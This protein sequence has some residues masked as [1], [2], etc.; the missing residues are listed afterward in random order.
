MTTRSAQWLEAA[1][2]EWR[3]LPM[4][5]EWLEFKEAKT[6]FDIEKLGEYFSA[7]SNEARLQ[8]RAEGWLIFG[9]VDRLPRPIVGTQ[10]KSD[11]AT[12]DALK[13]QVADQTSQRLTF[14]EIHELNLPEGRVLMFEI[15]AALPGIPTAWKGHFFGRDGEA[16]VALNPEEYER[17][18]AQPVRQDWS[19]EV[20][21][22]ATLDDLEPE[23]VAFARAQ[24]LKKNP[25]HGEE[26]VEWTIATF[27]NKAKICVS[28]RVTRA[29]L[30]LLGKPEAA[31]HLSPAVAEMSWRLNDARGEMRDYE[32]FGP[33]F[34]FAGDAV[35][36]KIRNLK[37]RHMP[38]GSLF[39]EEVTQ[40]DERVLREAL[41]NCIAHQDYGA[42]ARVTIV[43][44]DDELVLTN[45]GTFIPRTV[46]HVIESDQPPDVYR[47][48]FLAHAMVNLNMIDTM[49]SGIRRM[50]NVQRARSF[51]LP[52]YDLA[53]ADKVV[54]RISG[55]ILDVNY[56]KLLLANTDLGLADVIALDKVQKK[57]KLDDAAF[58]RLRRAGLIAGRRPNVFVN[59]S[60]AA[61]TNTRAEF[62]RN[63]AFDAA[64]YTKMILA[65]LQEYGRA[66]YADFKLLLLPKLSDALDQTQKER[67]IS[68]LLQRMRREKL[69]APQ[70]ARSRAIWVLT[71]DGGTS[72]LR[73]G[74][75]EES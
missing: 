68:N 74:K 5:T 40:Y 49:G 22:D 17:I 25:K 57:K 28:G 66:S 48:P 52:D 34:L 47:N 9:V 46:E 3:A 13:K 32:H 4:E 35:L 30:L 42:G 72:D 65:Y 8:G 37:V 63:R 18:R 20:V 41:H 56:T 44:N 23:A 54:V 10:F 75:G 11:P 51:P 38:G 50:F 58:A 73:E 15:P 59:A 2:H 64:H 36:K 31:H 26:A 67:F 60:V 70:G 62:I 6:T 16:L 55:R 19:A 61:A 39:P 24:Y 29:A 69:I 7:L 71:T 45:R 53:A 33:P 12:R 14:H 21:A 1:L 27:L 43:E